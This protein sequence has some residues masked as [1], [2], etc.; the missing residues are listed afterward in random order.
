MGK[1]RKKQHEKEKKIEM[2]KVQKEALV[3]ADMTKPD[4]EEYL[5]QDRRQEIVFIGHG[6]NRQAIQ[7]I[8]DKCLL[9]DE[10]MAL[11]PE[12]W[13][14][15]MEDLDHIKLELRDEDADYDELEAREKEKETIEEVCPTKDCKDEK[16]DK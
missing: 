15:T 1:R 2:E 14:E 13:K 9:T 12:K 11:G 5:F 6:T 10:E 4:G 8:L 16:C 7:E 3:L